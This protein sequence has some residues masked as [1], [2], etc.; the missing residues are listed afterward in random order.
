MYFYLSVFLAVF[1]R[2]KFAQVL[3]VYERW[4]LEDFDVVSFAYTPVPAF[5][6][7][8]AIKARRDQDEINRRIV[9]NNFSND[10]FES[11]GNLNNM[12][13]F[14]GLTGISGS[15]D[16]LRSFDTPVA[17]EGVVNFR[18]MAQLDSL[19]FI[20]PSTELDL[21][22]SA[23]ARRRYASAATEAAARKARIDRGASALK[24][25]SMAQ[26]LAL[27]SA[28]KHEHKHH[29]HHRHGKNHEKDQRMK[30]SMSV[31]EVG[32]I[33]ADMMSHIDAAG[34]NRYIEE[35]TENGVS[36]HDN[37][38]SLSGV[39]EHLIGEDMDNE[40]MPVR[41]RQRSHSDAGPSDSMRLRSA[42]DFSGDARF[43]GLEL[44]VMKSGTEET[45]ENQSMSSATLVV[46][47]RAYSD[48]NIR[49]GLHVDNSV[50]AKNIA[51][52]IFD[53]PDDHQP[54]IISMILSNSDNSLSPNRSAEPSVRASFHET[55]LGAEAFEEI[56]DPET[57]NGEV[58]TS[59]KEFSVGEGVQ[60][61]ES[62]AIDASDV[63]YDGNA[64]VVRSTKPVLN[65][66]GGDLSNLG[67]TGLVQFTPAGISYT[68]PTSHLMLKRSVSLDF[69]SMALAAA[70]TDA[71]F[72]QL[73]IAPLIEIERVDDTH[74]SDINAIS[75][76]TAEVSAP[77]AKKSNYSHGLVADSGSRVEIP[78]KGIARRPKNN[79]G[80][81]LWPL[82]HQQVFLGMS[83]SSVPVR[84]EA[85]EL[86]EDCQAAG[87]RFVFFSARNMRRSKRIAEKIGLQTD[88]NCAIS[89]R[90]LE[91]NE[92]HDPN[93]FEWD[94]KAR[95]PH[96]VA[97]IKEHLK[98]VDN[99]PLLVS[100]F[101]DSTPDTIQD[102]IDI[103]RENGE[104]VMTIGSAYRTFNQEIF[105]A[106]DVAISVVT[107][108]GR[109]SIPLKAKDL[110]EV[111][112]KYSV[113]TLCR[114]DVSLVFGLISLGTA[115]LLQVPNALHPLHGGGTNT[116]APAAQ[117]PFAGAATPTASRSF[118]VE[119][120]P[121]PLLRHIEQQQQQGSGEGNSD[122]PQLRLPAMLESVRKCRVFLLNIYQVS[123]QQLLHVF[124]FSSYF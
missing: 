85:P 12:M 83:A 98:Y 122:A 104:V 91:D 1:L 35:Q 42:L 16:N 41:Y 2:L 31:N 15:E 94:I 89:L 53:I 77:T 6:E 36:F 43:D 4:I 109:Q 63:H 113:G 68:D 103:F 92:H 107:M 47:P 49:F 102:M 119:L 112:P 30:R 44:S 54:K 28:H 95:L 81:A 71:R 78:D 29:H 99:V 116:Q 61:D 80:A 55:R 70:E 75:S 14:T 11:S 84:P 79:L 37:R 110:V 97:A 19:F 118:S 123:F 27:A 45:P 67:E 3:S 86:M 76:S 59:A 18:D 120:G 115:P 114:A 23:V 64:T 39:V 17:S 20:D 26:E 38:I 8:W 22:L 62:P 5:L 24:R 34:D 82:M 58:G 21:H 96:G 9:N 65:N 100:L 40:E 121:D 13:P 69:A 56:M 60:L 111:F 72:Q 108:P 48:S 33:S 66:S 57:A 32:E 50:G 74:H 88:W 105:N 90:D 7:P 124:M 101:S 87:I 106:S 46:I 73:N 117:T 93:R 52:S 10:G 25:G 51:E